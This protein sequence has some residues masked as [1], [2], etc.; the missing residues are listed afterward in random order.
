MIH[1]GSS[2]FIYCNAPGWRERPSVTTTTPIRCYHL[3]YRIIPRFKYHDCDMGKLE[4]KGNAKM[5]AIGLRWSSMDF[6]SER[7]IVTVSACYRSN[8]GFESIAMFRFHVLA[9]RFP[10]LDHRPLDLL[11]AEPRGWLPLSQ[12]V[13]SHC[14]CWKSMQPPHR[15]HMPHMSYALKGFRSQRISKLTHLTFSQNF[16]QDIRPRERRA[17]RRANL[18]TQRNVRISR[19]CTISCCW[20]LPNVALHYTVMGY[21]HGWF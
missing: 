9:K 17:R 6:G 19:L 2:W 13:F 18:S 1:H 21:D 15:S 11:Q 16:P 10:F 12:E 8:F 5:N 20:L 14:T 7:S 4:R 3:L